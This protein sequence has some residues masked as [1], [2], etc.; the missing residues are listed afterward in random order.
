MVGCLPY[1]STWVRRQDSEDED[2]AF[3]S[4]NQPKGRSALSECQKQKLTFYFRHV[5]DLNRDNVISAEDFSVLTDVSP[6]LIILRFEKLVSE[7][8][9]YKLKKPFIKLE[10][11]TFRQFTGP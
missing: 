3:L 11:L 2:L 9:S 4:E 6:I 1:V 10:K 8:K 5:L 7:K